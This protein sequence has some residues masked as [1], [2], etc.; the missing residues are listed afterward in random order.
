MIRRLCLAAVF[1]V[2]AVVAP[3]TAAEPARDLAS[4]PVTPD[5][6]IFVRTASGTEIRGRFVRASTQALVITMPDGET[7]LM[8][9]E[10]MLVWKRGDGLR[11]GAII[12]GLIGLVSGIFGQSSCTDCS[13]EIAVAVGL[14][15]PIWAGIGAL[16]DRAHV[17]R[18]LIYKAP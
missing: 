18:T 3:L 13:T 8:S 6:L 9:G 7:T 1:C 2:L 10:V 11:N 12:G 17:G 16:V 15:V 4:M 14:G 5:S